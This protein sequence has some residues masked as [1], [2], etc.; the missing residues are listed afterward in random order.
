MRLPLSGYRW[1]K[2]HQGE[3]VSSVFWEHSM[4]CP[5]RWEYIEYH[6][7]MLSCCSYFVFSVMFCPRHLFISVLMS[8]NRH[9]GAA[10]LWH[11][12]WASHSFSF[13]HLSFYGGVGGWWGLVITVHSQPGKSCCI[14]THA[15]KM[16]SAE[17]EGVNAAVLS[18]SGLY[19]H[20]YALSRSHAH[21]QHFI[22]RAGRNSE[23]TVSW[24]SWNY[25]IVL[26]RY[27]TGK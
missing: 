9:Y 25:Y 8:I 10:S 20:P 12:T 5:S 3:N 6:I 2:R 23:Q 17:R 18:W 26:A 14:G 4:V 7:V 21:I 13:H 11:N 15:W 19:A 27:I 16:G 1:W 24:W 22:M